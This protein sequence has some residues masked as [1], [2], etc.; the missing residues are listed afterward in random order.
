MLAKRMLT[1]G[2]RRSADLVRQIWFKCTADSCVDLAAQV[3]FF[4]VLSA[5]PFLLMVCGLIGW[6]SASS[7]WTQFAG[8]LA[9]YLPTRVQPSALT[10]MLALSRGYGTFLSFGLVLT[11]W[12]AS[13]G[14]LSLMDALSVAHGAK[15]RRSYWKRR[16]IAIG[17]TLTAVVFIVA[18]FAIW[19]LGRVVAAFVSHEY[20]PA[21]FPAEWQIARWIATLI[22]VLVAVDLINCFLPE[23]RHPWKWLSAGTLFTVLVF[24]IGG[25]V[26]NFYFMH[27][28]DVARIYGALGAFIFFALWIYLIS[29]SLLVGAEADRAWQDL[30]ASARQSNADRAVRYAQ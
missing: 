6:I 2:G 11:L 25:M 3:S 10:T 14:F 4:F 15:H 12:S 27:D 1:I 24:V 30:K 22:L 23:G 19:N 16:A 21:L 5:F 28:H 18:C 13:T 20:G 7:Q 9:S 29:L 8:W 26:L 17:A